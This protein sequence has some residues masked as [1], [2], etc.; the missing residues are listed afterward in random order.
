[1]KKIIIVVLVSFAAGMIA[2]GIPALAQDPTVP[3]VAPVPACPPCP[4]P[5]PEERA[6]EGDAPAP[7]DPRIQKAMDAIKAAEAAEPA[8]K[9]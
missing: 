6:V 9:K 3:V 2:A 1:M 4:C 7:V 5:C 8:E